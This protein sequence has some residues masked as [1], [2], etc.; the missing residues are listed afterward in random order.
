MGEV[1]LGGVRS[2]GVGSDS[3]LGWH[4][5]DSRVANVNFQFNKV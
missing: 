5:W 3:G 4:G 2:D 1:G